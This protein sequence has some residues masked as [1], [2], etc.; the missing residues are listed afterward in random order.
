MADFFQEGAS[1][2]IEHVQYEYHHCSLFLLE[3][4]SHFATAP[5]WN[6]PHSPLYFVHYIGI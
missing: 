2:L 3:E 6:R 1:G 5:R 4:I